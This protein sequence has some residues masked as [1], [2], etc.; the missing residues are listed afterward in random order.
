MSILINQI[1]R[2]KLINKSSSNFIAH[3]KLIECRLVKKNKHI[4]KKDLPAC[5]YLGSTY[6]IKGNNIIH[7]YTYID[8]KFSFSN[9]VVANDSVWVCK[10]DIVHLEDGD[11]EGVGYI[12]AC[13]IFFNSSVMESVALHFLHAGF[14]LFKL[15]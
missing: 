1:S 9:K 11:P 7:I 6:L 5:V 13:D 8:A 15:I 10:L 3:K 14:K 12:I 4:C 2:L